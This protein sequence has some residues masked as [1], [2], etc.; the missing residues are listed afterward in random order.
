M[1]HEKRAEIAQ[2]ELNHPHI[3]PSCTP[4][5]LTRTLRQYRGLPIKMPLAPSS[6]AILSAVLF[7]LLF[8]I[9]LQTS[10]IATHAIRDSDESDQQ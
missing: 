4:G 7:L 9:A 3:L 1:K 2:S 8:P 6:P 5:S 10:Q